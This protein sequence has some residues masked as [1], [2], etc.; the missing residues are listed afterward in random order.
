MHF[1]YGFTAF[2]DSKIDNYGFWRYNVFRPRKQVAVPD[3][4]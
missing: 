2:L 4:K 1:L 3:R